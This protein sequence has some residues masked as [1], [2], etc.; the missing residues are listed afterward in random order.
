[1]QEASEEVISREK[2]K[3]NKA[4]ESLD[5]HNKILFFLAGFS[6]IP[7]AMAGTY[8]ANGETRKYKDAWKYI[9]LSFACTYGL[10]FFILFIIS[11]TA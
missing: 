10:A 4:E 9:K 6:F 1:M 7:I 11:L 5:K 3:K 2:E 8:K